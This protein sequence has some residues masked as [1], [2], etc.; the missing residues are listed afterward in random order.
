MF[1]KAVRIMQSLSPSD[2]ILIRNVC[3]AIRKSQEELI[4]AAGSIMSSCLDQCHGICCKN[5]DIDSVFS[6]WDF[7]FI[8]TLQPHFKED[9]RERL[10]NHL[11]L[12]RSSCPFLAEGEG[13]CIFPDGIKAQVCV[14][15][16]CFNV[17]EIRKSINSVNLNFYKLCWLFQY[18]RVK[19]VIQKAGR[20]FI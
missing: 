14:V 5:L 12:V 6:V 2:K 7:V 8:L 1:E 4:S 3:R 13:P 11:F 19:R 10:D 15:T 17:D 16:F 9:I 18:I 20:L